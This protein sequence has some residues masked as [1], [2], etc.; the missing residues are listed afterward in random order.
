MDAPNAG[1]AVEAMPG[2]AAS[3]E[4]R[5]YG[6]QQY[7]TSEYGAPTVANSQSRTA[8]TPVSARRASRGAF[9]P[10][11]SPRGPFAFANTKLS[12]LKS[13]CTMRP[14]G[15]LGGTCARNHSISS[16]MNG[17]GVT[18]LSRYCRAHRSTC[19]REYASG[20]P[21][22]SKPASFGSTRCSAPRV[23]AMASYTAARCAAEGRDSSPGCRKMCPCAND[24][25]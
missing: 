23:S 17:S 8:T 12:S 15:S 19:R 10:L 11:A 18:T 25:R 21:K 22:P 24:I 9:P 13:P 20:L 7:A 14:L 6:M 1:Y 5:W 3:T 2:L 16:V 4:G